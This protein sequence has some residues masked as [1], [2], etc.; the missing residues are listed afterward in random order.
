M[1]GAGG[2][3]LQGARVHLRPFG[4]DDVGPVVAACQDE[5]IH[6]WT[7]TVPRPYTELH[8]RS[9]IE[10]HAERRRAGAAY[11]FAVVEAG[12]G[13]FAGSISLERS[14]RT[15]RSAGVGYWIAPWA[16]RRGFATE[17][18]SLVA[19]FGF[20]DADVDRVVLLTM[21]GN[22]ASEAVA[23]RAGFEVVGTDEVHRVGG[24]GN[25]SFPVHVWERRRPGSPRSGAR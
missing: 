8:A 21:F 11:D 20:E 15:P 22:V 23:R 14:R 1:E 25:E 24:A 5:E 3:A 17:A 7:V 4:P 19:R 12:T 6:R 10:G 13:L 9:W 16:R 2:V 18:L